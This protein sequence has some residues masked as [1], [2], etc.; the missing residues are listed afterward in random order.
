MSPEMQKKT[1]HSNKLLLK[2]NPSF[3]IMIKFDLILSQ[4]NFNVTKIHSIFWMVF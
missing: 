1:R 4:I 2:I 3:L